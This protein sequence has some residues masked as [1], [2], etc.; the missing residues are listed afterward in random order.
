MRKSIIPVSKNDLI[1]ILSNEKSKEPHRN[2]FKVKS[3]IEA[4]DT[5]TVL[6]E[7]NRKL[8]VEPSNKD[9]ISHHFSPKSNNN[10][11]P[12][13]NQYNSNNSNCNNKKKV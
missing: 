8:S 7:R 4:K 1:K 12:S 2:N 5:I 11:L 3:Y 10:F 9:K 13:V 6:K